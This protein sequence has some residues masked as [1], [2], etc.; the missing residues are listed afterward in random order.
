MHE[1][2]LRF[3][4]KNPAAA[5]KAL[6][7]DLKNDEDAQTEL[8]VEKAALRIRLKSKKLSLL[9]AIINSYISIISMLDEAASVK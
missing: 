3:E 2:E 8:K 1:V 9:K 6:E 7:P 5:K 4:C